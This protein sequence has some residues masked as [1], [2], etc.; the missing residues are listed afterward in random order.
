MVAPILIIRGLISVLQRVHKS[1]SGSKKGD[2][3]IRKNPVIFIPSNWYLFQ[4]DLIWREGPF[5]DKKPEKQN[6]AILEHLKKYGPNYFIGPR[7]PMY[8]GSLLS[9]ALC[10]I[11]WHGVMCPLPKSLQAQSTSSLSR[12]WTSME[13]TRKNLNSTVPISGSICWRVCVSICPLL[14]YQ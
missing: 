14:S 5:Q 7:S 2:I 6:H 8:S 1:F 13:H 4:P 9:L 12:W 3:K 10:E 11:M